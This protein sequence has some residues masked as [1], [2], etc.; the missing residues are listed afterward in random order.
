MLDSKSLIYHSSLLLYTT[1]E[2]ITAF[3]VVFGVPQR[4]EKK[5]EV[6]SSLQKQSEIMSKKHF[7][8]PYHII[9]GFRVNY[10]I[11][12]CRNM[13]QRIHRSCRSE[14]EKI[15]CHKMIGSNKH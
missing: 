9:K 3:V 6:Y 7:Y 2:G 1:E 5:L 13:R 4:G 14:P 12:I 11:E 15:R 10:H 8:L